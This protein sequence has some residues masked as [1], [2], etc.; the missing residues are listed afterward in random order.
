MLEYW[1]YFLFPTSRFPSCGFGPRG[2][3]IPPDDD[4]DKG[5]DPKS[6][7]S[8]QGNP[9]CATP[10]QHREAVAEMGSQHGVWHVLMEEAF[11]VTVDGTCI[12]TFFTEYSRSCWCVAH[13][14]IDGL[15]NISRMNQLNEQ[16]AASV[17]R[18][19]L[20]PIGSA[21]VGSSCSLTYRRPRPRRTA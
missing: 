1:A 21:V 19:Q 7:S 8:T 15:L 13:S 12:S 16:R 10:G 2:Q 9:D 14:S 5:R 11:H 3:H 17:I 6:W 20:E 18:L 4:V